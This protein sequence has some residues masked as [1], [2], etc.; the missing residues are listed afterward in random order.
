MSLINIRT[1]RVFTITIVILICS[2]LPA[3][4]QEYDIQTGMDLNW[5][6]G[7]IIINTEAFI[8]AS[9][10]NLTT[11]RFRISEFIDR[12]LTEI[13]AESLDGLYLDSM[14]TVQNFLKENQTGMTKFDSLSYSG[15]KVS[16]SLSLDLSS[17]KNIYEYNIYT[18][19]MPILISHKNPAPVP[20]MLNF[21]PTASFSG[22]V[23]Y[24]ADPLPLYGEAETGRL[25][26][27]VFPSIYDENMNIV[28]SARM[29][30]PEY[31]HRWGFTGYTSTIDP[32]IFE[33]RVGLYP[34][35]T[36]ASAL[37]GNNRT[38]I[39]ISEEAAQKILYNEANHRLI[40]EGRILI[41]V[42]EE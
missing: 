34:F 4:S 32:E 40:R 33:N 22:I 8:P 28:A 38:D 21:E 6:T 37:F 12:S 5:E 39:L 41:I 1:F 19:L 15:R 2:I 16:S 24:A 29:T 3:W 13:A 36:T 26:P 18:D 30:E 42:A 25:N 20:P 23:I 27:A 14:K 11:A 9:T 17:V 7:D 31:L 35:Y 10:E